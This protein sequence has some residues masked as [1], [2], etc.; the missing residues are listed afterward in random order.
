MT[1]GDSE[2]V[3]RLDPAALDVAVVD[4]LRRQATEAPLR[5][6]EILSRLDLG[7]GDDPALARS[8]AR[9]A[10]Q[11]IVTFTQAKGWRYVHVAPRKKRP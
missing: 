5:R 2:R 3:K 1:A 7:F 11:K 4:L 10:K 9:L 6:V 8:L